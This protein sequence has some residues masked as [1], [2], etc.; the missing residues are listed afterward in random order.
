MRPPKSWAHVTAT[1]LTL[2]KEF[3]PDKLDGVVESLHKLGFVTGRDDVYADDGPLCECIRFFEL[4]K[5]PR[6]K[7]WPNKLAA[8]VRRLFDEHHTALGQLHLITRV[9]DAVTHREWRVLRYPN[10]GIR[11]DLAGA[12]PGSK[13]VTLGGKQRPV[14][15][16][17]QTMSPAGF[18]DT[19]A[20]RTLGHGECLRA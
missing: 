9:G 17:E 7:T 15:I 1:S 6:T 2:G 18:A 5:V 19:R 4:K 16:N 11:R 10:L 13:V 20:Y 14:V 12:E 8:D 3:D